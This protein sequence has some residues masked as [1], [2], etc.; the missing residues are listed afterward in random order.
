MATA[1]TA[2]AT[3]TLAS[4]SATVTFSSI[5]GAYRDLRLVMNVGCSAAS[6]VLYVRVNNDTTSSMSA[7]FAGGTGSGS[8]S[9]GTDSGTNRGLL[10]GFVLVGAPTTLQGVSTMDIM[11]YSATDKHKT[12]ITRTND[13]G[14]VTEMV[15]ARWP[16][17][18]AITTL[19]CYWNGGTNFIAGSTFTLYGIASA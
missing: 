19:T 18:S 11:D 4:A 1:L 12:S 10:A 14:T 15:A 5:S 3:T 17:T 9:S 16:Q 13:A 7:V 6:N 8:G 2:L